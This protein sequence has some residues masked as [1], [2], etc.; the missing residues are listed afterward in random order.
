[1]STANLVHCPVSLAMQ[2]QASQL[3][4]IC[5]S[6]RAEGHSVSPTAF[7]VLVAVPV[8]S[9]LTHQ[10]IATRSSKQASEYRHVE[11]C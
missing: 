8:C 4:E 1:M 11:S 2:A 3:L 10:G 5:F 7:P 6:P 9:A